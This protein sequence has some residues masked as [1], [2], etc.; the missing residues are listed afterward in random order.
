MGQWT[1]R[2]KTAMT[3]TLD[4]KQTWHNKVGPNNSPE[5]WTAFSRSLHRIL[6]AA[7]FAD[8]A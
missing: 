5:I 1:R 7:K 2:G 4:N 6:H 3:Q 8:K